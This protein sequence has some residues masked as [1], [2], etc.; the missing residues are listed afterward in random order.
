M[1]LVGN[2]SGVGDCPSRFR[3]CLFRGGLTRVERAWLIFLDEDNQLTDGSY[4]SMLP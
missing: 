3:S 4:H 1:K 2:K